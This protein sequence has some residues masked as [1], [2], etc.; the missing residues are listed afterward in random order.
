MATKLCGENYQ[1][2]TKPFQV[3]LFDV[4]NKIINTNGI[5]NIDIAIN[6]HIFSQEF[7]VYQSDCA[8]ILLGFNFIKEHKIAI[9]PNLGLVFE[10]HMKICNIHEKL[11]LKC[12]LKILQDVTING[13]S[14]QVVSVYLSDFPE[15]IDQQLYVNGTY[16]AHSEDLEVEKDLQDLS[17]LHQYV[18]VNASL[19]TSVLLINTHPAPTVFNKDSIIGHLEPTEIISHVSE[20][21]HDPLLYAIYSCFEQS[22]IHPPESRIFDDIMS[23]KFDVLDINCSSEAPTHIE[24]LK[25]LHLKYKSIFNSEEFCP[26]KYRGSQVHFS[27]KSN[28][29]IVNQRFQRINPAIIDDAQDIINHLLRRGLIAISDTPYCSR[30]LFVRKAA[31]EVQ[32][33]DVAEA[34]DFVPGEKV[35]AN[36]KRRLRLV[37]DMRHINERLKTNHCTWVTPNIW[38]ILSDFQDVKYLSSID[39]NSGFWHF[40]LSEKASLYTGFDFMGIRYICTRNV[41]KINRDLHRIAI[42][43]VNISLEQSRYRQNYDSSGNILNILNNKLEP[44]SELNNAHLEQVWPLNFTVPNEKLITPASVALFTAKAVGLPLLQKAFETYFKR[45]RDIIPRA[46]FFPFNNSTSF[47]LP[48]EVRL[49]GVDSALSNFSMILALDSL[50]DFEKNNLQHISDL[51]TMHGILANLSLTNDQFI[52]FLR[53]KVFN[54]MISFAAQ[55]INRNI[56]PNFPVLVHLTPGLSFIKYDCFFATYEGGKGAMTTYDLLTF[57]HRKIGVHCRMIDLPPFVTSSPDTFSFIFEGRHSKVLS[58]CLDGV[59]SGTISDVCVKKDYQPN[60]IVRNNQIKDIS[61]Y[62]LISS[63]EYPS[64][65][66]VNCPGL[67]QFTANS[68]YDVTVLAAAPSCNI[69]FV[70]HLGTLNMLGNQSHSDIS[71]PPLFYSRIM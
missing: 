16:L 55:G 50:T 27:L 29:T 37:F 52:E 39:L 21:K 53:Q 47:T 36:K 34:K 32:R 46:Q 11:N 56:D 58:D 18:T 41:R 30:V 9:F 62:T 31:P 44:Q 65:V 19:I 33:K 64:T 71:F 2:H 25:N 23:F 8:E 20:L 61:V 70:T 17:L 63:Y 6:G 48:K 49:S 66:K 14:Q 54:Y 24:Y 15:G 4:N 59:L 13:E 57:P 1:Q 69:G 5:L 68:P 3:P 51:D 26:G 40:P 28:A 7:I 35:T 12:S 22:D 10:S 45:F 43:S 42:Q 38:T 60:A 67:K